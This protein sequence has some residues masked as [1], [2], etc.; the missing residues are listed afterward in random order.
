[1]LSPP[2]FLGGTKR[3]ISDTEGFL[4][5]VQRWATDSARV[6][7]TLMDELAAVPQRSSV[8]LV[9][10]TLEVDTSLL[11]PTLTTGDDGSVY[12][13]LR[14]WETAYWQYQVH[15]SHCSRK[16]CAAKGPSSDELLERSG[17]DLLPSFAFLSSSRF[18]A[19]CSIATLKTQG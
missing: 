19:S 11:T 16:F 10:S 4:S 18:F 17:T 14:N 8:R 7:L 2:S 12:L 13:S 9:G 6:V 15:G 1:M 5:L 3:I